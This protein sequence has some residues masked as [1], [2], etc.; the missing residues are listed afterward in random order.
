MN[1]DEVSFMMVHDND[2]KTRKDLDSL[3]HEQR[4]FV[5]LND[6]MNKTHPNP[7]VAHWARNASLIFSIGHRSA[8]RLLSVVFPAAV[9]V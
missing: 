2:T 3:R 7:K 8:S 6:D 9:P 5:C 4:K 1:L